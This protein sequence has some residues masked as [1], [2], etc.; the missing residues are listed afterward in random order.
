MA[1]RLRKLPE[2]FGGDDES[3]QQH[4]GWWLADGESDECSAVGVT[5]GRGQKVV[6]IH[7]Q[8]LECGIVPEGRPIYLTGLPGEAFCEPHALARGIRKP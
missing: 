7:G 1:A 2:Y 5:D 4:K 3:W 8:E 6:P